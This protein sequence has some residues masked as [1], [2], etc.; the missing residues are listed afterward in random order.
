MEWSLSGRG[1]LWNL[2]SRVQCRWMASAEAL[3]TSLNGLME[4]TEPTGRLHPLIGT[5]AARPVL[6]VPQCTSKYIRAR[7]SADHWQLI[8][9]WA[10]DADFLGHGSTR[11]SG[12]SEPWSLGERTVFFGGH[13]DQDLST[14]STLSGIHPA[15]VIQRSRAGSTRQLTI[16]SNVGVTLVRK[17]QQASQPS[18]TYRDTRA[19]GREL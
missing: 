5:H 1:Q 19:G 2:N 6:I 4:A 3:P 16:W 14:E 9:R 17:V 10:A 18:S 13:H 8:L 7:T 11:A 15:T 12:S